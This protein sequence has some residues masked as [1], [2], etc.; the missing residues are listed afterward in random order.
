MTCA[1]FR[2]QPPTS[3]L[4]FE[5]AD[6]LKPYLV[7]SVDN[8]DEFVLIKV[9]HSTAAKDTVLLL[10]DGSSLMWDSCPQNYTFIRPLTSTE[11]VV[12][13]G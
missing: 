5:S 7:T 9:P 6:I 10:K 8:G 11:S 13:N 4:N 1:M 12:I 3:K 2:L